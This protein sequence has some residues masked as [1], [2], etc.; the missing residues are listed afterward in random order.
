MDL[1]DYTKVF[2]TYF[3][4]LN[5]NFESVFQGNGQENFYGRFS[6]KTGKFSIFARKNFFRK[7]ASFSVKK[8]PKFE[9]IVH[10][11]IFTVLIHL[12]IFKKIFVKKYLL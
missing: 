1:H 6:G 7:N 10:L 5:P 2:L 12:Y 3:D 9:T 11:T 4:P 8:F